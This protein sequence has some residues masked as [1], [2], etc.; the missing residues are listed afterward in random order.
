MP[1]KK[2]MKIQKKQKPKV[3]KRRRTSESFPLS[4]DEKA[5][6]IKDNVNAHTQMSVLV[7]FCVV[8]VLN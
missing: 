3:V 4:A 8:A 6:N 1:P 2:K 7:Y 5:T